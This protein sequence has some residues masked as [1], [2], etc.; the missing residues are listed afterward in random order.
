MAVHTLRN[1][2]CATGVTTPEGWK[3]GDKP[4]ENSP[5]PAGEGAPHPEGNGTE[6][7]GTEETE[8][9]V[10]PTSGCAGTHPRLTCYVSQ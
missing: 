9:G 10:A 3:S 4:V 7:S 6:P 8:D 1:G 5:T 2:V